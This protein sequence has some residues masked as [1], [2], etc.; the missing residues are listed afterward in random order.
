LLDDPVVSRKVINF[1]GQEVA[2]K[3]KID[4]KK[5][6]KVAFEDGDKLSEL[7]K[8]LHP[9]ILSRSEEQIRKHKEDPRTK[10]IVLDIPLLLE[11]G[12]AEKCDKLVFV[13]CNNQLRT[14]RSKQKGIR[15]EQ[16]LHSREKFQISMDIKESIADNVIDNDHD[17]LWLARQVRD[18]FACLVK[19][20]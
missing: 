15:S 5:L 20:N 12:W 8:L 6:A 4:R 3:G 7:N 11:V 19:N 10:A 18:I 16:G 13:K 17:R 2:V 9:L 14:K 1:F